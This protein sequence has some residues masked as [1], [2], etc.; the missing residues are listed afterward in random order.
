MTS[1][2]KEVKT[3]EILL[4]QEPLVRKNRIGNAPKSHRQ[5]VPSCTGR[6]RVAILLPLDLSKKAMVLNTFSTADSIVLRIRIDNNTT[7]LL[8]SIYMDITQPVPIDI[9]SRISS[10]AESESLPLVVATDSN[11]H[12]TAW[13]H[14]SCNSRGRELLLSLSANNLILANTGNPRDPHGAT[15]PREYTGR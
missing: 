1:L 9:I 11:A 10:F 5:F 13:G 15:A 14:R 6:A 3:N 8:A 7:L 12:H 2:F 4:I